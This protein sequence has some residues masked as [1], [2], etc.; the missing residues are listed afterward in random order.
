MLIVSLFIIIFSTA[1]VVLAVLLASVRMFRAT[2]VAV[3]SYL[4][5]DLTPKTF[6]GFCIKPFTL[7]DAPSAKP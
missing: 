6:S 5:K 1:I 4:C 7:P 3:A 2:A